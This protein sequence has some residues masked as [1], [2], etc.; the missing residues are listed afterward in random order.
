MISPNIYFS[1]ILGTGVFS[2]L[3]GKVS[4]VHE[5]QPLC[6]RLIKNRTLSNFMV[7]GDLEE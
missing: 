5:K 7:T 6:H 4:G 3:P 2:R 1:D